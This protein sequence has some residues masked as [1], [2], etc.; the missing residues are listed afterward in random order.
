M[1]F[2]PKKNK[3]VKAGELHNDI[4]LKKVGVKHFMNIIQGYGIQEDVI[5][6]LVEKGCSKIILETPTGLLES[7]LSIWLE[8]NIKVLN[9]GHGPQRF[10]PV[11]YMQRR[12][13]EKT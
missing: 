3:V 12:S 1:T 2:D 10:M 7:N 6:Q 11:K 4:F 5:Q 8:P 13:N 9:Y